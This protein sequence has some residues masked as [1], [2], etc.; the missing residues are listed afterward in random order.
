MANKRAG[1]SPR[2][3]EHYALA[4]STAFHQ[5][6]AQRT[7]EVHA[8]FFLPYLNPGMH[9]IDCGCGTGSITVALAEAVSPG[10]VTGIEIKASDVDLARERAKNGGEYEPAV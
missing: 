7:A 5:W 6:H 1:S 8:R 2:G 4:D 10:E 9:L 3:R